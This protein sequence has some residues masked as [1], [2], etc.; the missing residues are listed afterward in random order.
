MK[1]KPLTSHDVYNK[2]KNLNQLTDFFRPL[3]H[4]KIS[5]IKYKYFLL[6]FSICNKYQTPK[7]DVTRLY[8][9]IISRLTDIFW[10]IVMNLLVF[11]VQ[12]V[13]EFL[14]INTR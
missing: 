3:L 2:T 5:I 13:S 7:A 10:K 14:D 12:M 9:L 11:M 8:L 1:D 4:L 6:H